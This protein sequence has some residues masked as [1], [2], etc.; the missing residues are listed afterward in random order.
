MEERTAHTS[1]TLNTRGTSLFLTVLE[2]GKS[3]IKVMAGPLSGKGPSSGSWP[4][5]THCFSHGGGGRGAFLGPFF[6]DTNLIPE[7]ST[8]VT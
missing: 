8:H 1:E 3:K 7:D 5:S 4:V 2:A 6:K